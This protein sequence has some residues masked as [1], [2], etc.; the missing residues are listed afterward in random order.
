MGAMPSQIISLTIVYSII[1]SGADQRNIKAPR[2]WPL[3][4]GNWG[5]NSPVTGEFPAQRASYAENI[6]T[7][8]RHH[9]HIQHR[10][11]WLPCANILLNEKYFLLP[12]TLNF[13][14]T[15][16]TDNKSSLVQVMA[17]RR[18]GD[19]PLPEPVMTKISWPFGVTNSQWVKGGMQCV[20]SVMYLTRNEKISHKIQTTVTFIDNEHWHPYP[21]AG[22]LHNTYRISTDC[23]K[24]W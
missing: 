24:Y 9:E 2:H 18:T 16:T 6:S 14:T 10:T 3:W 1:Y 12:I 4:G 17:W 23:A 20:A 13:V 8:W 11:K 5:G 7:W 15:E 22:E 19:K 21:P